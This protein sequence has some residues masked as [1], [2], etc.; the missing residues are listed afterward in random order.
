MEGIR[1]RREQ[2]LGQGEGSLDQTFTL[3]L[4][5]F[6]KKE[7]MDTGMLSHTQLDS[8]EH[9]CLKRNVFLKVESYIFFS[10]R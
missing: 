6:T 2:A 8:G 5:F 10:R 7:N 4:I 9:S 1:G 3:K